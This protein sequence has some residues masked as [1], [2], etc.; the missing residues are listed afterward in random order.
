MKA[1]TVS[2]LENRCSVI[3]ATHTVSHGDFVLAKMIS[4]SKPNMVLLGYNG[5]ILFVR[6]LNIKIF[7]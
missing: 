4:S 3:N 1:L 6:L 7:Q 2:V 5:F